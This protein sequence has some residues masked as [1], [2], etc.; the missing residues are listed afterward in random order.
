MGG[1]SNNGG[2]MRFARGVALVAGLF[3]V[4]LGVWAFFGP[5]SFFDQIATFPPFN[6]HLIH[7]I[8][9]FQ[10]G[11]GMTLLLALVRSDALAVALIGGGVGAGFH[12]VAHWIDKDLGGR[13]SDPYLLTALALVIIAAG[14]A[15]GPRRR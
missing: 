13:S 3:L 5:R 10:I 7:D 2:T 12:A 9:A 1:P 14:L 11:I 8:G 4:G 15:Q 6:K